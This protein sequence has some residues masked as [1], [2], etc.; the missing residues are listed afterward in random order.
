MEK[1]SWKLNMPLNYRQQE[2]AVPFIFLWSVECWLM[3]F[4]AFPFPLPSPLLLCSIRPLSLLWIFVAKSL[5][6]QALRSEVHF[7]CCNSFAKSLE[8]WLWSKGRT[9]DAGSRTQ[10]PR[11]KPDTFIR[12]IFQFRAG[13]RTFFCMKE[14]YMCSS[15]C[16]CAHFILQI[17]I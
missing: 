17:L 9:Q 5:W 16:V 7:H 1:G 10:N 6:L 15:L 4:P 8:L 12:I 13:H 11:P 14:K 2:S 3:A